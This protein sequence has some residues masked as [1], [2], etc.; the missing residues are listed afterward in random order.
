MYVINVDGIVHEYSWKEY[1]L[2]IELNLHQYSVSV[3]AGTRK[4]AGSVTMKLR[5]LL[6]L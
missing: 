4:I 2:N 5:Y 1:T 3:A 6:L